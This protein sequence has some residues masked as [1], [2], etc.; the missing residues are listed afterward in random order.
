MKGRQLL[1][2][3]TFGMWLTKDIP[4]GTSPGMKEKEVKSDKRRV[5]RY[6]LWLLPCWTISKILSTVIKYEVHIGGKLSNENN[7]HYIRRIIIRNEFA[8]LAIKLRTWLIINYAR[9]FYSIFNGGRLIL[10]KKEFFITNSSHSIRRYSINGSI[11]SS[12]CHKF[13]LV[14][15]HL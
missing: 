3:L 9:P 5:C 2:E 11:T 10:R 12:N 6:I 7:L 13:I 14:L 4:I 8:H 15:K 1:Q